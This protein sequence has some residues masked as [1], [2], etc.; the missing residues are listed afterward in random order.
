MNDLANAATNP[1]LGVLIFA[2][3]GLAGAVFY[4]PF[5]KVKN[6][7]WE[8]YWLVY[9]LFGLL[10]VPWAITLAVSP[11]VFSVLKAAPANEIIY[12]Y[13]CGAAWG[14]GGLTWGL[15]IRYLGVGLGLAF[16]CGIC[17]A[18][19]T[20]IPKLI[21]GEFGSLFESTA[22]IISFVGVLISL[23]G[24][25]LIGIAGMSKEKELS[26]EEKKKGVAEFNFK[27]GLIA[28]L[29]SGLMSS[30]MGLGLVGGSKIQELALT[31]MPTTSMTW[32][33]MPVLVVVLLGG[34][35]VNFLWCLYLNI[36][37]KTIKDYVKV[38]TPLIANLIFAG[39]AGAIWCSQFVCF[40]TGEPAMGPTAY[41]GWALLM[42]CQILFGSIIG[43]LLGEWK[44]TSRKTKIILTAG[45]LLLVLTS[46]LSGYGGKLAQKD[47]L[48]GNDSPIIQAPIAH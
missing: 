9:A 1:T 34:L 17:S 35:T 29:F 13:I 6:W 24:I 46:V 36:K 23:T 37:N 3:G 38:G 19:G 40:K 33:G 27:K 42:A 22:G 11:N 5:K 25:V 45:L 8:S 39:I 31:T 41:V 47:T 20:L 30:A 26:D 44:G 10:I 43:I 18:A 7:A 32:A 14:I 15:M 28:A 4:L 12:C 21:R 2:M 16:G 48:A